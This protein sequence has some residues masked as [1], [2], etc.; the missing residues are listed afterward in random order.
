MIT[1]TTQTVCNGSVRV[2]LATGH[3]NM[4]NGFASLAILVQETLRQDP[5]SCVG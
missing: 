4:R 2:W 5:F 3:T 1:V